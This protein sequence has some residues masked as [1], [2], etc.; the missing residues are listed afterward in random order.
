MPQLRP[1]R[2]GWQSQNMARILLYEFCFLSEPVQVADDIGIDYF[3]TLFEIGSPRNSKDLLPRNS[4]AIQIKSETYS[5][6]LTKHIPYLDALE[7]PYLIEI[8]NRSNLSMAIFSGEFLTPFFAY[9]GSTGIASFQARLCERSDVRRVAEGGWLEESK[10]AAG[11]YILPFPKVAEVSVNMSDEELASTVSTIQS[12][13]F[14]IQE[15][16]AKRINK[17]F[18]YNTS[19]GAR[20]LFA[21]P[22][23]LLILK[24]I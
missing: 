17:Q 12:H 11:Q 22:D 15:N 7:L 23:L 9:K 5:V 8:V 10:F 1:F 2:Y 13:C 19:F 20:L 14:R 4:F 24:I 18:V 16:I 3:C 21:G 6:D